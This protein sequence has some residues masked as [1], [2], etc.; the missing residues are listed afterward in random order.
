MKKNKLFELKNISKQFSDGTVALENINLEIGDGV[1]ALIGPSGSGKSTLLRMLNL[2]ETPT[3]GE[4]YYQDVNILDKSFN[5]NFHRQKVGMVFQNFH[6]FPHLS[7]LDNLNLPQI[8]VLKKKKEE[9]TETSMY[10]LES[11]GLIDKKDNYPE[12]LSGGQKQRIAIARS[13]C[14]DPDVILFDE[15]TSALDPE[16]IKEVLLVMKKLVDKGMT[17]IIVTHEM[18]FAQSFAEEIIVMDKGTIIERGTPKDIF[19]NP[20]QER[21]KVFLE[22][23]QITDL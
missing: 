23:V 21:T 19:R 13:L 1:T 11:V 16:M 14:M 20:Q 2:L 3:Y 18:S 4:I 7:I 9:A 5:K 12:Q 22:S 10:F 8:E 17:M 6:L 15:P